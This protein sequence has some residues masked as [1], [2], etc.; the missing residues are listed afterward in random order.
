MANDIKVGQI[1]QYPSSVAYMVTEVNENDYVVQEV[2]GPGQ[3]GFSHDWI[4]TW[5]QEDMDKVMKDTSLVT[6]PF[7]FDDI[8]L[9]LPKQVY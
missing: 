3:W 6:E 9:P 1:Y 8:F 4:Q 2:W 7:E 5:T